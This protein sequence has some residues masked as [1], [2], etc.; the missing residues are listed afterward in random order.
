MRMAKAKPQ[1]VDKLRA[2][3]QFTE[4][5]SKIDFNYIESW[6]SFKED[7]SDDESFSEIIKNIEDENGFNME[8]YFDYF[9]YS[10]S[11]LYGRILMGFDVLIENCCNPD[12]DY[13]DFNDDIKKGLELLEKTSNEL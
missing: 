11:P 9:R 8:L 12:L 4:H 7:W 10:I 13:L 6:K 5:V 1:H 3:L 2:W